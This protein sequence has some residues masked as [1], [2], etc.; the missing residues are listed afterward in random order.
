[1]PKTHKKNVYIG[2]EIDPALKER[3]DAAIKAAKADPDSTFPTSIARYIR[4]RIRDDPRLNPDKDD[5]EYVYLKDLGVI[6]RCLLDDKTNAE[7]E[8]S[9]DRHGYKGSAYSPALNFIRQVAQETA[10]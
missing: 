10:R 9:L 5:G 1:M 8:E 3:L 6:L 7:I 4:E 2:V